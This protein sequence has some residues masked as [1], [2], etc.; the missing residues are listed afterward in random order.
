[1]PN[2]FYST[3]THD[4]AFKAEERGYRQHSINL[5]RGVKPNPRRKVDRYLSEA[6]FMR[7]AR[8]MKNHKDAFPN[9]TQ[10]LQFL[11]LTRCRK[12]EIVGLSW[13]R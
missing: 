2:T 8:T 11:I 13:G 9:Q 10:A 5:C 12:Q 7:L 3:D 6:E 1:M 4:E